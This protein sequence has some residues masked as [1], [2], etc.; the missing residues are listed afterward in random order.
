VLNSACAAEDLPGVRAVA[1]SPDGKVLAAGVGLRE[2]PGRLA[3][4][5]VASRRLLWTHDEAKG[6][7]AIEFAPDG[8]T[9]AIAFFDRMARILDAVTGR[10]VK[11]IAKHDKE[12]R[13]VAFAPD[14]KTLATASYDHTVKLWD[15]DTGAEKAVL[16]GHTDMVFTVQF[17]PDGAALV[18]AGGSDAVRL[19]DVATGKTRH[20]WRHDRFYNRCAAFT[21]D[22]RWVLT[23]GY[24]GTV[25]LWNPVTGGQRA[26]FSGTGG[27]DALA[28]SAAA[29]TLA[30]ASNGRDVHLFNLD[31]LE[32]TA[33]EK[34][35]I[36]TLLA[37]FEDDSYDAREA[38]G[39]DLL[40][41]GFVAETELRRAARESPSAEVRIRACR[42]REALL[43]KPQALV[44]HTDAVEAVAFAPDGKLLASGGKD[45]TVR[46]W[47]LTTHKEAARLVP[48]GRQTQ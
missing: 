43:S 9:L 25:R 5:D 30:V 39:R 35:R 23:G 1:F 27:V 24:E 42:V 20:A 46:L 26:R 22:G 16:E 37:R 36:D 6:V 21:A 33:K 44:G 29:R 15:V 45:G 13:A 28:F 18:S 17:S 34:Q 41:V 7:C 8:K 2:Q 19:W 11:T 3:A 32:P 12:V 14:G 10:V 31:L 4:W 47:D 38:A 40:A 48:P